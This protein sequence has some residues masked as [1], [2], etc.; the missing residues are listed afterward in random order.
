[1][2]TMAMNKKPEKYEITEKDIETVL[3][4]LKQSDP[5]N[6]TPEMAITILE[7]FQAA[8]HTAAHEDPKSLE[9]F[10]KDLKEEKRLKTN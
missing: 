9:Q 10:L 6:A 4:I 2:Y 7:Q 8:F 3:K 1:M 5:K